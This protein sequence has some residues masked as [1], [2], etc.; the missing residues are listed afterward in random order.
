MIRGSG[1]TL[2]P[3]SAGPRFRGALESLRVCDPA[4][5]PAT[6]CETAPKRLHIADAGRG[7]KHADPAAN[8]PYHAHTAP[9]ATVG[10]HSIPG[11]PPHEETV[12]RCRNLPIENLLCIDECNLPISD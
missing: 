9:K 1:L 11:P 5:S 7:R 4:S 3:C 10:Y 6:L 12:V 2:I 8:R